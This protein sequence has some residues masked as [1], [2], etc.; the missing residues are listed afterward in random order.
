MG[1]CPS[2]PGQVLS[3][4]PDLN[5]PQFSLSHIPL[6]SPNAFHH[7]LTL[8]RPDLRP[9]LLPSNC[10]IPHTTAT[11]PSVKVPLSDECRPTYEQLQYGKKYKWII[12]KLT[13]KKDMVVVDEAST[14]PDYNNFLKK[15]FDAKLN[16]N[17]VEY[18]APRFAIYDVE[19]DSGEGLRNKIVGFMWSPDDDAHTRTR[20]V[21]SATYDD[22]SQ[23]ISPPVRF[24]A[25]SPEDITE[26]EIKKRAGEK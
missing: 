8:S 26:A 18:S 20:M 6:T 22:F 12:Y 7:L 13:D 2:P 1:L 17:G 5:N 23:E 16:I 3:I 11:M 24:Q 4:A 9:S 15:L 25:N 14:D 21:Y 19:Y 10:L